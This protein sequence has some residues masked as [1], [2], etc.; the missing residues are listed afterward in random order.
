[1]WVFSC[2]VAGCGRTF[3][4]ASWLHQHIHACH[5]NP[6]NSF[7]DVAA[8]YPDLH[9]MINGPPLSPSERDASPFIHEEN[10]HIQHSPTSSSSH[11]SSISPATNRCNLDQDVVVDDNVTF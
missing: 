7:P 11:N 5:S 1:M 2:N 10:F 3:K 8:L 4:Q 9:A 6:E